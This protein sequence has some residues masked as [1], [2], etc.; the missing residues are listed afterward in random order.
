MARSSSTSKSLLGAL[1]L[2]FLTVG[3]A[4]SACSSDE[5][6]NPPTAGDGGSSSGDGGGMIVSDDPPPTMED[7]VSIIGRAD[8]ASITDKKTGDGVRMSWP[9][10]QIRAKFRGDKVT[11]TFNE[12]V[13][14]TYDVYNLATISEFLV[15][16]DG[17]VGKTIQLKQGSNMNVE[18]WSGA[19]GEHTITLYRRTEGQFGTTRFGG[20]S[21]PGGE[22][23]PIE[24]PGRKLL[25][26]G[27]SIIAGYGADKIGPYD[28]ATSP[29][30]PAGANCPPDRYGPD[31]TAPT[32]AQLGADT[33][34]LINAENAYV[35]FAALTGRLL[36]A[37]TQLVAWSGL[38][39]S[40]SRN[41]LDPTIDQVYN[42]VI[43]D[44]ANITADLSW[45]PQAIVLNIGTNDFAQGDPGGDYQTK[46]QQFTSRLRME[47]PKALIVL[48]T[49]PM[50][51]ADQKVKL[52]EYTTTTKTNLEMAG[53]KA[54]RAVDVKQTTG[55]VGCVY[56][57][58]PETH[59]NMAADI[60]GS[61]KSTLGWK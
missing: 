4:L 61:I 15:E 19:A 49:G 39:M 16:V 56:H 34:A 7:G 46:L 10:V 52:I 40:R 27:D 25:F 50:V 60:V 8:T 18:L 45:Q 24:R 43:S 55:K 48:M 20:F 59:D 13:A 12:Q 29:G 31:A 9:G 2:S 54:I 33:Q 23:L 44:N 37:D 38:G 3:T 41:P 1:I 42:R 26:I 22:V 57:P 47:Y 14:G 28:V 53:D 51:P 36:K 32:Q 58:T 11:A 21:F 35:S 6:N 17:Q 30:N 5:K